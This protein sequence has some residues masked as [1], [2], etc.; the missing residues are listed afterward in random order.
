M[1]VVNDSCSSFCVYRLIPWRGT[2]LL[3]YST[4]GF[5]GENYNVHD[6]KLRTG[7]DMKSSP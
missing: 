7:W 4:T 2:V 3:S 6:E 1:G 5:Y